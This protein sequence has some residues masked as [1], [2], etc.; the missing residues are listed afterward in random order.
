MRAA[1]LS[2]TRC[3]I[4]FVQQVNC[5][6]QRDTCGSRIDDLN[7]F[8]FYSRNKAA[9]DLMGTTGSQENPQVLLIIGTNRSSLTAEDEQERQ[10]RETWRKMHLLFPDSS[11][12]FSPASSLPPF[13][14]HL[15]SP[16]PFFSYLSALL[17]PLLLIPVLR[18]SSFLLESAS[19]RLLSPIGVS[20]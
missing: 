18:S 14:S 1:K 5:F 3:C 6:L 13:A 12:F 7:N 11:L 19:L 20:Y 2:D 4:M 10:C 9:G 8:A 15:L 16:P 17:T